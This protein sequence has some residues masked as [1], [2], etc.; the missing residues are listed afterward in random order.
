MRLSKKEANFLKESLKKYIAKA[1]V[2]LFGS[3]ADDAEK[4][5][6]IDVL[7]IGDRKLTL[8]EKIDVKI[9]F[10]KK[11][12]EQKIDIVS[13]I[14]EEESSFKELALEKAVEL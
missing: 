2:Y 3:R 12:G 1:K 7:I 6:D 14:K 4:G 5:G 9:A 13:F 11:F 8:N 10:Y